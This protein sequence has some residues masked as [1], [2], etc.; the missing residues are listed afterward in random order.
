MKFLNKIPV[1]LQQDSKQRGVRFR[2]ASVFTDLQNFIPL[3]DLLQLGGVG[4]DARGRQ[5]QQ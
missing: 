1:S 3:D 2:K 4:S 5:Q